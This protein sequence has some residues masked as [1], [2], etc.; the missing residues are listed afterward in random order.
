VESC[1]RGPDSG[2]STPAA[3]WHSSPG[4]WC[5]AAVHVSSG[6][7]S[8]SQMAPRPRPLFSQEQTLLRPLVTSEKCRYCC[9]SRKSNNQKISRKLILGFPAAA[10]LFSVTTATRDRFWMKQYGVPTSPRVKRISGSKNFRSSPQKDFCNNICQKQ[11]SSSYSNT[12]SARGRT[13]GGIVRFKALAVLTFTVNSNLV[14]KLTGKLTGFSPLRTP[15][16][17]AQTVARLSPPPKG[18]LEIRPPVSTAF[19]LR[20]GPRTCF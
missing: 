15:R 18:G 8:R 17:K 3:R 20:A 16:G 5:A 13:I 4:P 11:P 12:S 9:K 1:G 6:I 10:S 2:W 14:G 19:A 7:K